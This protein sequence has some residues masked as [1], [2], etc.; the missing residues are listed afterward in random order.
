MPAGRSA[1]EALRMVEEATVEEEAGVFEAVRRLVPEFDARATEG[2]ALRTMPP[3]LVA[4]AKGSGLFRLG[5]PRSLGG[6]ELDPATQVAVIEEISRAD[7]SA[8]WTIL[9]GNSTAFFAWLD[10]VAARAMIGGRTEFASTSMW[11]PLGKVIPDGTGAFTLSGRWS[12]NSGCQHA[13][14]LQVGAFVMDGSPGSAPRLRDNG[15]PDWRF[16]FVPREL[17]AIE[18]DWDA[19]DL[20]GTGSHHLSI[21]NNRVPA[22][23]LAAP[24]FEPARHD[25]PLWRIPLVT[26]AGML[27]AGFPLGVARRAL[28]E[29]TELA[30]TKVRGSA[31]EKVAYDGHA[32]V[33]LAQNEAGLRAARAFVFETIAEV[34]RSACGG[35]AP[36]L[37]QRARVLLATNQAMRAGVE[38]VDAVFRLAGAAAVLSDQ[39]LQRC[40][41]D[42][43]AGAQHVLF[44][45]GRDQ[46]FA[47]L[48]FGIE[49]PTFLI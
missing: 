27:M 49:Q 11:A 33:Q 23:H 12:F 15:A 42:I 28:D 5:L 8:G 46:A 30:K 26:Q 40:L 9:I 29:F 7:G 16:A 22:E 35:D 25:G 43:H 24:F 10:P 14:W 39:R 6:L 4:R 47:K 1:G 31:N 32:Q 44:G 34:W 17:A 41:R 2:E 21:E 36:T 13:E 37:E 3:D 48:R 19:S 20:R 45:S 38:A 18:Q